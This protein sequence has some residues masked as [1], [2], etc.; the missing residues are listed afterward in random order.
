MAF[1]NIDYERRESIAYVTLNRPDK[2]NAI[3]G[4]LLADFQDA[5]DVVEA[6]PDV[7]VVII[8]GAGRA[9]S[10]G[11]DITPDPDAPHPHKGSADGWRSHLQMLIDSFMKVWYLP[12][13]VI[14][15]VNGYA[16]GG[17]CELVQVCDVKIASEHAVL[18]E[19]EI[20][21]GFGPP[22]L[23]TPYSVN[24]ANAK[25]L[26]LTGDTVDAHE[27]ARLG[28]VNRVVPH[29]QLME[30]CERV[31]KKMCLIP[32]LGIKLTKVA[33][34]RALENM[35]FLNSISQNLE[36]MTIFDT[37]TSPEQDEFNSIAAKNGLRAALDWRDAR[38]SGLD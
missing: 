26:L 16:L 34:N 21:A 15:A 27:A 10:A 11:F 25:E 28:L 31:A 18:G 19:P 1:Q 2:L 5:M 6:D 8:T 33:V 14:A 13:P 38:F 32:Q 3:N 23:V 12:K 17:A 22:L 20:R 30:E 36:L 35:G 7:R 9:F 37:S 29:E 4:A 24:L